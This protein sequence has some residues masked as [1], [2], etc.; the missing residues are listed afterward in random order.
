M[1][2]DLFWVTTGFLV[3]VAATALA[4]EV[5][6]RKVRNEERASLTKDWN[7]TELAHDGPPSIVATSLEGSKVPP[8][9]RVLV[10][11]GAKLSRE[12]A[13][14]CKL[15]IHPDAKGNFATGSG[16][17]V[18]CTGPMVPGTLALTTVHPNLVGKL[19][20][21]FESLWVQGKP[22][23]HRCEPGLIAQNLDSFIETEGK[24]TDL[25]NS[26]EKTMVTLESLKDGDRG[27]VLVPANLPLE[28]GKVYAF[29]GRVVSEGGRKVLKAE[30]VEESK[31]AMPATA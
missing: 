19:E 2:V 7:F 15:R 30:E 31:R 18:L 9:S 10:S 25:L 8:G 13:K 17:A 3:G 6:F 27:M 14:K 16:R 28:K 4:L 21:S 26:G 29:Q 22:Y 24:V 1:P 5:A 23:T 20:R 11:P 12:V